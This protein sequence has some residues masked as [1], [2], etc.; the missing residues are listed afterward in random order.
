[1]GK[2]SVILND[3]C[4]LDACEVWV[5]ANEE[6][7]VVLNG[8]SKMVSVEIFGRVFLGN[9]GKLI[10][11][12]LMDKD[13]GFCHKLLM[14]AEDFAK[15]C[16]EF[17]TFV[18]KKMRDLFRITEPET[19][20]VC[21]EVKGL[22]FFRPFTGLL[23]DA[24]ASYL[25][26]ELRAIYGDNEIKVNVSLSGSANGND[27]LP[28]SYFSFMRGLA[29]G[30]TWHNENV[31]HGYSSYVQVFNKQGKYEAELA[32]RIARYLDGC[33]LY[34]DKHEAEHYLIAEEYEYIKVKY[35][36]GSDVKWKMIVPASY[37]LPLDSEPTIEKICEH[38]AYVYQDD[39]KKI[40]G[41][42]LIVSEGLDK[43]GKVYVA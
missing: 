39:F 28:R 19:G 21:F 25:E 20:R 22:D 30:G 24:V 35:K 32:D 14:N 41:G 34:W 26:S 37:A 38:C 3:V 17:D 8:F 43:A 2:G 40:G 7:F 10:K 1:M 31:I 6:N 11:D 15:D 5:D 27:K 36:S 29:T 33:Y 4:S 16:V 12:L 18:G 9:V 42:T 13:N 23:K